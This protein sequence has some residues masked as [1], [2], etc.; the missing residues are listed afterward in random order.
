MRGKEGDRVATVST[1][2][3]EKKKTVKTPSMVTEK[4]RSGPSTDW[5]SP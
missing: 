4:Q 1:G 5:S 2:Q 3:T